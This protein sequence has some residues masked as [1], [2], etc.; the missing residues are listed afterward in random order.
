LEYF[1]LTW[2]VLETVVGMAAGI[3][4]GSVAL[5]GFALDSVVESTSAGVL[6]WRI[7]SEQ[8][9]RLAAED[10][11]RR[12]VRM[13]AGAFF[14]LAI[15]VA[16]RAIVDLV[17]GAA[18]EESPVGIALAIISLIVMPVLAHRKRRAAVSMD[19]LAMHA[20][21][22]QTSLCTYISAFLLVGL[23]TNAIFGWWWADPVAGLAIAGLAA[24]E[25]RELWTTED[26][27]VH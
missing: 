17:Q 5:I 21:S 24:N 19:S 13:I 20:D 11:E 9:G 1:S 7:R 8:H 25:G 12:A 22:S 23:A 27:C 10:A 26:F 2:N 6:V 15:Y 3:A 16:G 18:P 14:L 4:A